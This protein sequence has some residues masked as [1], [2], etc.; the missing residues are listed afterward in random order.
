MF[1]IY[2]VVGI[3]VVLGSDG[4][5]KIPYE[6]RLGHL[7]VEIYIGE[8][9]LIT[10]LEIDM[11]INYTWVSEFQYDIINSQSKQHETTTQLNFHNDKQLQA[12]YIKDKITMFQLTS[13]III[14]NFTFLLHRC[15]SHTLS[16]LRINWF[17]IQQR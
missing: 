11:G 12:L 1:L 7:N 8:P 6:K 4:I 9:S 5:V 2:V 14:N 10:T 15:R 3:N 16:L 13:N 17:W